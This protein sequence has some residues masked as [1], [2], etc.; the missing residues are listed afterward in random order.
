MAKRKYLLVID[1]EQE[2]ADFIVDIARDAG[3]D[4]VSASNGHQFR[5]LYT[6]RKPD[7]VVSDIVMPGTDGIE[8][9]RWLM[10]QNS[11]TRILIASGYGLAYANAAKT[12]GESQG[13][14]SITILPKPVKASALR[15]FLNEMPAKDS[16]AA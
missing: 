9:I 3:Y 8:I 14:L 15:N 12:L 7:V 5:E 6:A 10:E 1:D 2:F 16:S 13:R 11:R 4:A